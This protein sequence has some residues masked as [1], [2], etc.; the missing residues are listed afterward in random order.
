MA[1]GN[2]SG[3]NYLKLPP[4][5]RSP[6]RFP[7]GSPY[8]PVD[9]ASNASPG[10][11]SR[12]TSNVSGEESAH[13]PMDLPSPHCNDMMG[14]ESQPEATSPGFVYCLSFSFFL[15]NFHGTVGIFTEEF[16]FEVQV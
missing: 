2:G 6:N 10:S 11:G 9:A 16:L 5:S 7:L 8:K 3:P 13:S 15:F 14:A 4:K 12:R 1:G